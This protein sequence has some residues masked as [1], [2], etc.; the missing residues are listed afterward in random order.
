MPGG[1]NRPGLMSAFSVGVVKQ[2]EML[3]T[4]RY[5]QGFLLLPQH[6]KWVFY[7]SKP[8]HRKY[9]LLLL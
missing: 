2:R 1:T 5:L 9:D 7:A 6:H 3:G 8:T 4:A